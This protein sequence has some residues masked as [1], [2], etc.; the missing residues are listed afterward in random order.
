VDGQRVQPELRRAAHHRRR[1]WVVATG[2]AT[3]AEKRGAAIG[4]FGAITGLAVASGPLVGGAMV[5]GISWEWIFWVNVPIGLLTIPLDTGLRL[6]PWIATF[7]TVGPAARVLADRIGERPLMVGGLTLQAIGMAWVALIVEPGTAYSQLLAPFVVA[8]VSMAIPA[9]QN[10]VVGSVADA[11]LGKAAGANP[12]V[13][14][15]EQQRF[16]GH[17]V[18]VLTLEGA[19]SRR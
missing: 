16:V 1:V 5:E 12:H 13:P 17:D 6:L 7:I 8:G 19:R 10:S 11:A 18:V 9:A 14:T 15:A 2:A 4:M 3:P